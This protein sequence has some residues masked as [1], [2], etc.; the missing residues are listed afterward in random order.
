MFDDDDKPF[1]MAMLFF[2]GVAFAAG[3][4]G[5][6]LGATAGLAVMAAA[7]FAAMVYV[8]VR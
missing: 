4:L 7:S 3:A 5:S 1:V 6:M 8:K 2:I